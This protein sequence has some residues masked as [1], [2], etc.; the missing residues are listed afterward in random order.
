MK[1]TKI[2]IKNGVHVIT[3]DNI[4]DRYE[5]H[6]N[7]CSGQLNNSEIDSMATPSSRPCC[8]KCSSSFRNIERLRKDSRLKRSD[9]Q[10]IQSDNS[11]EY[12]MVEKLLTINDI[13]NLTRS[14][15]KILCFNLTRQFQV[16]NEVER[17]LKAPTKDSNTK[18]EDTT[19]SNMVLN[20]DDVIKGFCKGETTP[21]RVDNCEARTSA[22]KIMRANQYIANGYR[23]CSIKKRTRLSAEIINL[24]GKGNCELDKDEGEN[25][26]VLKISRTHATK[27]CD[28]NNS[29]V[30]NS[31]NN[32]AMYKNVNVFEK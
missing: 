9:L 2:P 32:V 1:A 18:S 19:I 28:M 21:D 11:Y 7:D 10:L 22:F 26:H 3:T 17:M 30:L 15:M 24:K 27:P 6:D 4:S 31:H 16:A 23:Y 14:A 13:N 29:A 12:L 25:E 8:K 5:V 20:D